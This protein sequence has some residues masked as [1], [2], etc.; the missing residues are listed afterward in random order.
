MW[1]L[2]GGTT[3]CHPCRRHQHDWML[4]IIA[5]WKHLQ[6]QLKSYLGGALIFPPRFTMDWR[7]MTESCMCSSSSE[8]TK[9]E[10][11]HR[12]S[13]SRPA[14]FLCSTHPRRAVTRKWWT[15]WDQLCSE[16]VTGAAGR[17]DL[18]QWETPEHK[19]KHIQKHQ[20]NANCPHTKT[21]ARLDT[22]TWTRWA[23]KSHLKTR[24]YGIFTQSVHFEGKKTCKWGRRC[25]QRSGSLQVNCRLQRRWYTWQ[26]DVAQ[27]RL[28]QFYRA[29]VRHLKNDT[30]YCC[31]FVKDRRSAVHSFERKCSK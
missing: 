18:S 7:P 14:G 12:S 9:R 27:D 15:L 11:T 5:M 3:F 29:A 6:K 2:H 13:F 8:H 30:F 25:K 26:T 10:A 20:E 31:V 17:M 16:Q 24:R 1:L 19:P 23:V 21:L 4:K 28:P 22:K